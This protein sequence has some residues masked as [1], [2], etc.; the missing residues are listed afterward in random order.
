MPSTTNVSFFFSFFPARRKIRRD[1]GNFIEVS[2]LTFATFLFSKEQ[3]KRER[4]RRDP[5]FLSFLL[6]FLAGSSVLRRLG[7]PR[8][9]RGKESERGG[10]PHVAASI[11][12]M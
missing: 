9:F 2:F 11:R 5:S 3:P 4:D 6:S 8:L 10:E 7:T 1:F 12:A